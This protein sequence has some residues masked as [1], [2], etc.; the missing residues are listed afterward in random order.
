MSQH[1]AMRLP[2]RTVNYQGKPRRV[3][4]EIEFGGLEPG[5]IADTITRLFG[6]AIEW[7]SPFAIDIVGTAFG[8]FRL[9]LDCDFIRK[10]GRESSFSGDLRQESDTLEKLS[11]AALG[12]VAEQLVPWEVVA[13]PIE[14]DH[15]DRLMPLVDG[16]RRQ[17]TKG[18]RHAAWCA[19]GLHLN[20]EVPSLE[21]GDL[22][23]L[24]RACL[25]LY[26]WMVAE[27]QVD[28][29]RQLTPYINHFGKKYIARVVGRGYQP[30]LPGLIDD[31]LD[32]NPTRNRSLDLLPL[33]AH[34]DQDRVRRVVDDPR[35]KSRPAFHY[36]LPNC[37]IDNP[38][39]N[40]HLPWARWCAV[41][42][43][44]ADP[45]SLQLC[46]DAYGEHL[47]RTVLPFDQSWARYVRRFVHD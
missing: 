47:A 22:L 20:P 39:W 30:D 35:V 43:L 9:E 4:I 19:F 37:D 11:L 13:P 41:E 16:L 14:F 36:R 46:C 38:Q 23:N 17:G 10:L 34:I 21:A 45:D 44:A 12:S 18:T 1:P 25:C 31:Y 27:E 42:A 5:A 8:D 24:G 40:L 29:S 26:D 15:L 7:Q 32:A 2:E 33:F 28:I 6:G 3:G